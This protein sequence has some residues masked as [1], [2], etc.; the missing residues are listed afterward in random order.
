MVISRDPL[1]DH[2]P[3]QRAGKGEEGVMC[4]YD[5]NVLEKIGLLKMDFLGLANLTI[6]GR[7]LEIIEQT[8]GEALDLQT[9]PLDDKKT[10]E[11]LGN[12][13]TTAIFQLE[14]SGMRRYI[15]ELKPTSVADLAAMVALYRPGP[16][17][18]HP[19]VHRRQARRRPRSPTSIRS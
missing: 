10:F 13:E 11:M 5:M 4:Q 3:L 12:G 19:P 18:R 2:V 14:G 8:R 17:E 9:I 15:K 7:A 1:V 6:L 16:D